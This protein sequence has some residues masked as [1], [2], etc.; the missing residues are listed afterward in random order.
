M[1]VSLERA[2]FRAG[3]LE[4][5]VLAEPPCAT[6]PRTTTPACGRE[7]DRPVRSQT[8][9][10]I[11]GLSGLAPKTARRFAEDGSEEDVPLEQA[12][13]GDWLRVRLGARVPVDG[14]ILEGTSAIEGAMVTGGPG[15]EAPRRSRHRRG[16]GR[17][18][19]RARKLSRA[20]MRNIRQNLCF[21]LL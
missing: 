10:A 17:G 19:V 9:G 1:Q 6:L 2:A 3:C 13:R 14:V 15:A 18:L 16:D 11:R 21:A 7:S 20:T 4:G 8:S 5:I 12:G